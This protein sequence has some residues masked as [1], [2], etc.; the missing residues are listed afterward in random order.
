MT[1]RE[2]CIKMWEWLAETG[3]VKDDYFR[4]RGG[5]YPLNQCFACERMRMSEWGNPVCGSCPVDWGTGRGDASCE[6]INS[7]YRTWDEI[8]TGAG[9]KLAAKKVL[10]C[11][12][13]TWEEIQ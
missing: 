9:R 13:E 7:P 3:G 12:E 2:K 4:E 11:I 1:N 5:P 6:N 8:G 10:E